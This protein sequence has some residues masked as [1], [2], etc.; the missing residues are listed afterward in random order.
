[1]NAHTRLTFFEEYWQRAYFS[2]DCIYCLR[3]MTM[4]QSTWKP[5]AAWIGGTEAVGALAGLLTRDG[6]KLYAATVAKPPLSP[7]PIVFP[8]AWAGLYALMGTGAA[9]VYL[10][11]ASVFRR[12]GLR[13]YLIQLGFNF[14]WS[15]IF[16][17]LRA[18]G[19]AFVWL[20]ALWALILM[21]TAVFR[22]ADRL[23]GLLQIPYVLWVLFA[24]YLNFGVWLLNG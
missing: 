8:I 14:F 13:L 5:Y 12:R 20:A 11:P 19:A 10:T 24:G 3:V 7:P 2:D 6:T 4:Q 22:R 23:A 16:F 21:M 17:N 9:R 15:L 18:Y 1:M